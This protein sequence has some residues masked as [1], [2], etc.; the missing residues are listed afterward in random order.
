[1]PLWDMIAERKGAGIEKLVGA[2]AGLA[3]AAGVLLMPVA[4]LQEA[5]IASGVA[6]LLPPLEPP[7]GTKARIGLALVAAGMA[8]GFVVMLVRLINRPAKGASIRVRPVK[9][10]PVKVKAAMP[11]AA[12]ADMP[13][14]PKVRRRDR[15]PDAPARAPLSIDEVLHPTGA[16]A[17]DGT[18]PRLIKSGWDSSGV[19]EEPE[20]AP[21]FAEAEP[22]PIAS[23]APEPE[24]EI[25]PQPAE[26]PQTVSRAQ[27]AWLEPAPEPEP[28]PAPAFTPEPEPVQRQSLAELV[29][30]L[31][32][33][34][35]RR[36]PRG[37]P[38]AAPREPEDVPVIS[39]AHQGTEMRLRDALESLKRFAPQRG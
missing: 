24:P 30:R 19:A 21:A 26:A 37:T 17:E 14:P 20:A 6:N 32:R 7:L 22:E 16:Q 10:K 2:V 3:T 33:A 29:E 23:V 18:P 28:E 4:V 35:E 31:E 15:H 8:F 39:E 11:V 12:K 36:T 25:V 5:V 1:M 9:E 38:A 13:V 27:P 34:L